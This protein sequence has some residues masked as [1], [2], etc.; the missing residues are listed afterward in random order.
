MSATPHLALP[1]LAAA[2]AQ[3]HV[4]HNEAIAALD[5]L[6]HLSVKERDRLNP[7]SDPQDGDR[8][9]VGDGGVGAFAGHG[10]A[11]ALFD[12]GAWRFFVPQAGWRAYVEAEDVLLVFNGTRWRDFV[13]GQGAFRLLAV[14]TNPDEGNP[15]SAKLN[16]TLFTAKSTGEGGTG[17]LRFVLNKESP[18]NVLSQLYQTGYGGRAETG[19]IGNDDFGIRVSTDGAQ[20]RDALRVDARTGT[21]AFPSGIATAPGANLLL[22]ASFL[23]NQRGHPG[24][25]LAASTY[26][27]DRWKAGSG[28][29]TVSRNADGSVTLSGILEQVVDVAQAP[30]LIGLPHFGGCTLTFSVE[31]LSAALSVT[32]GSRTVTLAEGAGRRAVSVSLDAVTT[33]HLLLRLQSAAATTFAHPKL[34]IGPNATPWIG[35]WLEAD[36]MRCRRYYQ[37]MAT[38]G[39]APA[40]A[41]ALGQ[42][43]GVNM[44]DIP[45]TFPVPM[46]AAPSVTTSGLVWAAASPTGNQAALYDPAAATWIAASGAV[47]FGTAVAPSASAMVL[48]FQ[49]I[50]S[51]SGAAGA[52]GL[53]HLGNTG[54][55]ALQAEL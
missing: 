15:L 11:I 4:T 53:L 42:R 17:D 32:I 21:V 27:F 1:L 23:V 19:L 39:S 44:I 35:D 22:N 47:G 20:W 40:M 48:R 26:G 12:L 33:S 24:G 31:N 6:V 54:F 37:R 36:E 16:A 38:S 51:F 34:E 29:C 8:Y 14:G 28:G 9:L 3:K 45:Y 2:Q 25:A 52:V 7:P 46:R 13:D 5:A 18:G 30:A 41:G 49:A 50:T 43:R 10:G 55:V